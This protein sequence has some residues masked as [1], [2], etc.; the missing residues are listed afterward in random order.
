MFPRISVALRGKDYFTVDGMLRQVRETPRAI[1]LAQVWEWKA[2]TAGD[3]PG[4]KRH[5][6]NFAPAHAFRFTMDGGAWMQWKQ[7][8]T[9]ESWGK[10]VQ[11]LSAQEVVTL[12]QWRPAE[13]AMDSGPDGRGVV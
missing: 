4:A 9:E 11:L 13:C 10:A 5:M 3:M 6:H 7:W 8:S 12:G 2:L 1:H